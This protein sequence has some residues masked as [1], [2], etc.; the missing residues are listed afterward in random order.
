[1]LYPAL[2]LVS[3]VISAVILNTINSSFELLTINAN[4]ANDNNSI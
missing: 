2:L 1:M 4:G 3:I